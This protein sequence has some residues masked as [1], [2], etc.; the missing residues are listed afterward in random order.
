MP[1]G[2]LPRFGIGTV[3]DDPESWTE[4][5]QTVL[6][7]GYRHIDS[8]QMYGNERYLGE[9]I[10]AS[11]VNRE[12]LFVATKTVYREPFENPVRNVPSDPTKVTHA[13]DRSLDRLGLD[14]IDLFYVH[15]PAGV[16]DAATVLPQFE[17]AYDD[18]KIRH[19]G[20]ANF[21]PELLDEARSVME[22]P[23]AAHQ[24][25]FHPF[26]RQTELLEYAREHDHWLVAYA[27]L[28]R[29]K[30]FDHPEIQAIAQKHGV[31]PAQ[32]SL[33]WLLSKDN[34]AVIP[35]SSDRTHLR[36]NLSSQEIELDDD[37]TDR[38]DGITETHRIV[39]PE[40]GAWR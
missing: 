27:P 29:G 15:W 1:I 34:V 35:K 10:A 39:D 18:G 2:S 37:D 8:G 31:T 7:L 3:S 5:I 14:Y 19:V 38:I 24:V 32:V 28:A 33:A 9:G 12:E 25:E 26:L 40:Y 11:S 16:Y 4:V 20:V 36:E 17:Q 30:V 21:T 6:E 22:V 13:I 23:I